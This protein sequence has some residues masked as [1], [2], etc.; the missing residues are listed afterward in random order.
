MSRVASPL[1]F[2]LMKRLIINHHTQK[3]IAMA[4][5]PLLLGLASLQG[6]I[7][8]EETR[9]RQRVMYES[10][11]YA[12]SVGKPM[13]IVG[14]PKGKHGSGNP[15]YGDICVDIDPMVLAECPGTGLVADIQQPLPF[16]DKYFGSTAVMHVLEHLNRPLEA[17]AELKRVSDRVYVAY[18]K[19]WNTLNWIHTDHKWIIDE[20]N[21][22]LWI[23]PKNHI[24]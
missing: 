8:L 2:A 14:R 22:E 10:E 3:L 1:K 15:E 7:L 5:T 13:L 6:I 16:P 17:I 4:L 24:F 19:R 18:P 9:E 23:S 21:G 20:V 11:F 12:R